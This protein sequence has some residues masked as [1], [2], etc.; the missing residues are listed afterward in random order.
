[1]VHLHHRS[2]T[3]YRWWDNDHFLAEHLGESQQMLEIVDKLSTLV[4]VP[5]TPFDLNLRVD[6]DALRRN[7]QFMLS[8]GIN[9]FTIGGNTGEF[10]SLATEECRAITAV[11]CQELRYKATV[12]AGIGY[13]T[14]T[15][16]SMARAAQECG[17]AAVMV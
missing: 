13:D 7:L 15:A 6:S 2:H 12:I 8:N 4:S 9:V 14:E 3:R 11:G 1:P 10:Y 16:I 17:A 5:V